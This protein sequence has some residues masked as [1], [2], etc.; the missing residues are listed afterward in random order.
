MTVHAN[1]CMGAQLPFLSGSQH[2]PSLS[3]DCFQSC[4]SSMRSQHAL[5]LVSSQS[6]SVCV[7]QNIYDE[8]NKN[9]SNAQQSL[10][11][12]Y[13]YLGHVGFQ[14]PALVHP[15]TS[16]SRVQWCAFG[17]KTLP[18]GKRP[19]ANYLSGASMCNIHCHLH[20]QTSTW[21][22]TLQTRCQT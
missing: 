17:S 18:V 21:R 5:R 6:P 11:F 9:L 15:R 10:K 20:A 12:I 7:S 22:Q 3:E 1:V 14:P 13:N 2:I 16:T 4:K 19:Q 8:R